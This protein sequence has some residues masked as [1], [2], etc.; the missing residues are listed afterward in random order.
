VSS[1]SVRAMP[2]IMMSARPCASGADFV[3]LPTIT[4]DTIAI[5]IS[6]L[7]GGLEGEL[8]LGARHAVD[9]DVGE[10]VAS[11]SPPAQAQREELQ[12]LE[13]VHRLPDVL[14]LQH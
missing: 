10:A 5:A 1:S 3:E 7:R 4:I 14:A 13:P 9:H 12:A 2:L 8:L 6:P 11:P